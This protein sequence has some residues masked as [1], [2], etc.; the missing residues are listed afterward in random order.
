[1]EDKKSKRIHS[2]LLSHGQSTLGKGTDSSDC[3]CGYRNDGQINVRFSCFCNIQCFGSETN[4]LNS[5]RF[6]QNTNKRRSWSHY[7]ITD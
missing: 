4:M 3:P 7:P 6:K 2:G 5:L 1:M